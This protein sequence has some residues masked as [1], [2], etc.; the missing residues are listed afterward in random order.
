MEAT[1]LQTPSTGVSQAE[2]DRVVTND[3]DTYL[4]SK[5]RHYEKYYAQTQQLRAQLRDCNVRLKSYQTKILKCLQLKEQHEQQKP[6]LNIQGFDSNP[7]VL[8]TKETVAK[9]RVNDKTLKTTMEAF[10]ETHPA[11]K[12]AFD[13][14]MAYLNANLEEKATTKVKLT[15]TKKRV[16]PSKGKKSGAN[17]D[18][19]DMEGESRRQRRRFTTSS[20]SVSSMQ[21]QQ[22]R[23]Q[24]DA[25]MQ[26]QQESHL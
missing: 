1:P 13:M 9:P 4:K 19:G 25:R 18:D 16:R 11:Y 10:L 26:L 12:Q 6:T 7:Y 8:S 2:E 3:V 22:E 15:R 17:D 14:F 5:L 20:P 21:F 23:A 24:H